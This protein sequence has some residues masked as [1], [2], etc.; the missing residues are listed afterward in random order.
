MLLLFSIHPHTILFH[1]LLSRDPHSPSRPSSNSHANGNNNNPQLS[2]STEQQ[3]R[4]PHPADR[5]FAELGSPLPLFS[6]TVSTWS[7]CQNRM[8]LV[9]AISFN[10]APHQ[11]V[12]YLDSRGAPLRTHRDL[13]CPP[14][15][16]CTFGHL[17]QDDWANEP[18]LE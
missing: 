6:P 13:P 10:T 9:I 17:R 14:L 11:L 15:A 16:V 3:L 4:T 12:F 2:H 18:P 5:C 7:V 8:A 1:F